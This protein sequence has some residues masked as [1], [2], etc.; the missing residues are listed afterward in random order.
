MPS[1]FYFFLVKLNPD[2]LACETGIGQEACVK[3]IGKSSGKSPKEI[4]ELFKHDGDLGI[5]V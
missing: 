1:L 3:A 5:V 4:R 2:Y